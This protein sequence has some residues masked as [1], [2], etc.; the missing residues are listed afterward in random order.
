MMLLRRYFFVFGL[1][2]TALYLNE[3]GARSIRCASLIRFK[4]VALRI[5]KQILG[6]LLNTLHVNT[7]RFQCE[8]KIRRHSNAMIFFPSIYLSR[9]GIRSIIFA[10]A[11]LTLY[12]IHS[13]FAWKRSIVNRHCFSSSK[14][15]TNKY[16]V[17]WTRR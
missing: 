13:V 8:H 4:Y 15:E 14:T 9:N 1:V 12:R 17:V 5:R 6:I 3:N 10:W 7:C 16:W 11:V 2:P